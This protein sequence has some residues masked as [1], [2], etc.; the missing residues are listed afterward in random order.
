[1]ASRS[2]RLDPGLIPICDELLQDM[3]ARN[4]EYVLVFL[5]KEDGQMSD[6]RVLLRKGNPNGSGRRPKRYPH[7]HTTSSAEPRLN[8]FIRAFLDF[9]R[10]EIGMKDGET[11]QITIYMGT[12][13]VAFMT[14]VPRDLPEPCE[15]F[16]EQRHIVSLSFEGHRYQEGSISHGRTLSEI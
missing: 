15:D 14:F 5:D 7:Q 4:V 3:E 2:P 11:A 8:A 16:V 10:D 9:Y 6:G 1:M 13:S 12:G